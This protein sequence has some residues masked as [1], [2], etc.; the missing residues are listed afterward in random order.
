[1]KSIAQ[2]YSTVSDAINRACYN[3]NRDSQSVQLLA[4][5][6][7]REAAQLEGLYHAGQ[8][9]FGENYLQEALDKQQLLSHLPLVWHFIGP[10][11]SNK[12]R[13]ISES[14][15]WVHSVDRLK[16]ARRLA[17]QRPIELPALN[18]C[19]QV[20]ISNEQSKAGCLVSD[21]LALVQQASQLKQLKVRGLMAIPKAT[22]DLDEQQQAFRALSTL[23][24]ECQAHCPGLDTLSMGMSADLEPAISQGA[25]MV[26]VGTAL[27]GPR[28][29][30]K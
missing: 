23:L 20:N 14:F 16:I 13:A 25:T 15:S 30:A 5:S 18:V 19:I 11:Q 7:T 3:A 2:N 28:D 29:Y 21:T 4:V 17:E 8:L 22:T 26:R 6:K 12:T 27:F 9:H 10:I 1:M 24:V